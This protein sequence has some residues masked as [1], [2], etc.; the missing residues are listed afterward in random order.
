L[1][2]LLFLLFQLNGQSNSINDPGTFFH[3]KVG[4]IILLQ[5]SFIESDIFTFQFAG[6]P[7]I[8]QQWM[9]EVIMALLHKAGGLDSLLLFYNLML[10][11]LFAWLFN[12]FLNSGMNFLL[13]ILLTLLI[14]ASSTHHFLLRPHLF[15]LVI[16]AAVF[17]I[18]LKY[19]SE[20]LPDKFLWV[21]PAVIVIWSNIHGGALGGIGSIIIMATGWTT[22]Y[23]LGMR[24]PIN[25]KSQITNLVLLCFACGLAPLANPYG[26]E[27]LK[28]WQAIMS[29]PAVSE[30]IK[31]HAGIFQVWYGWNVLILGVVYMTALVGTWKTRQKAAWYLPVVWFALSVGRIRH[32]PLFAVLAG[33]AIADFYPHIAWA[34]ALREKGSVL[35]SL[36]AQTINNFFKPALVTCIATLITGLILHHGKVPFPVVGYGW[37]KIDSDY[38]PSEHV[39][40]LRKIAA[41]QGTDRVFN[42]MLFGGFL[43]F[44]VPELKIAWDDRCELLK[45]EGL[46]KYLRL[47]ESESEMEDFLAEHD[48]ELA[49]TKTGT[50][51]SQYFENSS[52]WRLLEK[53]GAALLHQRIH[54][55]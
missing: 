32:S 44:Y 26:L 30:N 15:S 10:A 41:D 24:S 27:M 36:R 55:Q 35:F 33:I 49:L 29:S 4:Q 22:L 38:W 21:L 28:T 2:L 50:S 46:T 40:T 12:M 20:T 34:K 3:T 31:E 51:F 5:R 19:E 1:V 16:L 42:E 9:G 52:N 48:L 7:W 14:L 54:R 18:L 37:A 45:D 53:S 13:S 39:M 6:D 17:H 11:M 43:T 47:M 25:R 8:A 23:L